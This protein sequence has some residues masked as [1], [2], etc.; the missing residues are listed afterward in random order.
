LVTV[1]RLKGA[2]ALA[3][4]RATRKTVATNDFE[5]PALL[6]PVCSPFRSFHERRRPEKSSITWVFGVL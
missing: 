4:E 2:T 3:Q 5:A 6:P 1:L